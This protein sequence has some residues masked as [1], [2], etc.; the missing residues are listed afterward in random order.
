MTSWQD[1]IITAATLAFSYSLINQA[2]YG[3]KIKRCTISTQ[4]ALITML[5]L[6]SIS[7]AYISLSLYF[8]FGM[9]IVSG[10]LWGVLTYQS[11]VYAEEKK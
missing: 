6:F 3:Y 2:V 9:S 10:S 7:T 1:M 8:A 11:I 4:T 5:G